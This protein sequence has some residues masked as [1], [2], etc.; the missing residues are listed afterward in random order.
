MALK[1]SIELRQR[2][3]KAHF[4]A[5]HYYRPSLFLTKGEHAAQPGPAQFIRMPSPEQFDRLV[6]RSR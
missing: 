1:D 5:Q 6:R 3:A 2:F 4:V